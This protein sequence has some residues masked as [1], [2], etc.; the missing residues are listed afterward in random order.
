LDLFLNVEVAKQVAQSVAYLSGAAVA[1]T[2]AYKKIN[3][4]L[5][6]IHLERKKLQLHELQLTRAQ[7]NIMTAMSSEM[8]KFLGYK[9]LKQ[10]HEQT[11]SPEVTLKLLLAHYRRL[12][13][14]VDYVVEGKI[15]L[16]VDEH[17]EDR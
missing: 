11:K 4:A 9:N 7:A 2:L 1:A 16:P 10:L 13:I 15:A 14:L 17:V 6:D 3:K 12:G 5:A 8:A